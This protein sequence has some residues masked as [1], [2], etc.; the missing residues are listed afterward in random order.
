MTV[1]G[2][3]IAVAVEHRWAG[4]VSLIQSLRRLDHSA[5]REGMRGLVVEE[6]KMLLKSIHMR[7][8]VMVAQV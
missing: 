8:E 1:Q 6:R 2:G 7:L 5:V 4:K 3:N